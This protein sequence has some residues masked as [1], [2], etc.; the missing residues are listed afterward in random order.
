MAPQAASYDICGN[1]RGPEALQEPLTVI[2]TH[3]NPE[4]DAVDL[5]V[6]V[7]PM[8]SPWASTEGRSHSSSECGC[9]QS[10]SS[11]VPR[12]TGHLSHSEMNEPLS[13]LL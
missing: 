13:F 5:S 8:F 10:C 7:K 1:A 9:G 2:V 4:V 11:H 3:E 6:I 12:L